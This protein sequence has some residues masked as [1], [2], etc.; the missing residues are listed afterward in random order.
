LTYLIKPTPSRLL[1]RRITPITIRPTSEPNPEAILQEAHQDE[2]NGFQI[3]EEPQVC[4]EA[5]CEQEPTAEAC[6]QECSLKIDPRLF[7]FLG[8]FV[9]LFIYAKIK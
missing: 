2:R 4:Q 7:L 6:R 1:S 3:F 5:Q 9:R 8:I